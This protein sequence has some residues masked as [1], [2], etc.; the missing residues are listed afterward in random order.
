MEIP[1]SLA[2][3]TG[4][5]PLGT[6]RS[7]AIPPHASGELFAREVERASERASG[8]A[9]EARR[10]EQ[11]ESARRETRRAGFGREREDEREVGP[12]EAHLRPEHA[13]VVARPAGLALDEPGAQP[14][15]HR[16]Q[17]ALTPAP[18]AVEASASSARPSDV[19]LDLVPA[20][21][22]KSVV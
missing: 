7:S 20:R 13:P 2:A 14:A 8:S 21:D 6:E 11:L 4:G 15:P 5:G 3:G 12:R 10:L 19:L 9:A 16:D 1:A 17:P 18:A 22:R